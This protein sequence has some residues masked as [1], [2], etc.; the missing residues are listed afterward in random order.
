LCFVCCWYG[1]PIVAELEFGR[2]TP[3]YH[4]SGLNPYSLGE[5][6]IKYATEAIRKIDE[7]AEAAKN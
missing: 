2:V 5:D 6:V 4:L 7:A 1:L 3:S